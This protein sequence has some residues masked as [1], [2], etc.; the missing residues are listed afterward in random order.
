MTVRDIP[1]LQGG[2]SEQ[3]LGSVVFSEAF[4]DSS[5]NVEHPGDRSSLGA[6]EEIRAQQEY[7]RAALIGRQLTLPL[8]LLQMAA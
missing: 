6:E 8:F 1:D 7:G 2:A 4:V 3:P 5:I